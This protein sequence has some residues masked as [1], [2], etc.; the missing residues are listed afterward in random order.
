[1]IWLCLVAGVQPTH[2]ELLWKDGQTVAFLG[3]SITAQGWTN[4]HG[5]VRLLVDALELQGIRIE[6]IP[7]GVGGNQ[8][9]HMLQ[10]LE[11]DVLAQQPQWVLINCGMNDVIAGAKGT[12]I[13]AFE[14]NMTS[15]V[16]QCQAKGI[17]VLLLSTTTAYQKDSQANRKI[18]EYNDRLRQIAQEQHCQFVD[19]YAAFMADQ[20][21][22]LHALTYDGVHM[23]PEG[24][25]LMARQILAAL[26]LS[27]TQIAQA[28]EHWLD[29]PGLGDFQTRA[30][31]VLNKKF[32]T[33]KVSMTLRQRET[34]LAAIARAKRPTTTHWSRELLLSLMKKKVKPAGPYESLEALFEPAVKDKVQA[35]LQTEFEA[36]VRRIV[37]K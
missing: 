18:A 5:Y 31:I 26:G 13:D 7:A 28:R 15:I 17:K 14:K 3:D 6:P 34:L 1:M 16:S 8:S 10:R 37:G 19:L 30:D 22:T 20:S 11:R 23:S 25:M 29:L 27:E 9:H 12:P 36:E 32:M 35:E 21:D 2:A 33:A 24:N 4:S